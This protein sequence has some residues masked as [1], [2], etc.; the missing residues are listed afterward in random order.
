MRVFSMFLSLCCL[1]LSVSALPIELECKNRTTDPPECD[2]LYDSFPPCPNPDHIRDSY[3][4]CYNPNENA[5]D[6]F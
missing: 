3:A 5:E 6:F 4:N 1:L 2:P